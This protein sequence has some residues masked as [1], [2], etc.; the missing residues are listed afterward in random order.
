MLMRL[1]R[2]DG[3]RALAILLVI[4]THHRIITQVGWAGVDLFFVL[5]GF[6]ITRILRSS[7][8]QT[9]Y[10]SRFYLKRAVRILPP[11]VILVGFCA[12]V[13]HHHPFFSFLGYVLFLGNV[14]TLTRYDIPLLGVLWSLAVEEHF[15]L[16]WPLAIKFIGRRQLLLIL[17]GVLLFE[18]LVRA[19]AT[20]HLRDW[21]P[22]YF[23]TPFRLDSLAA[24]ALIAILVEDASAE[25]W[26]RRWSGVGTV[27]SVAAFAVLSL[28]VP[29]FSR[30]SNSVS[31]NAIGYSL[32]AGIAFFFVARV[33]LVPTDW[34]G[35]LLSTKPIV[36]LGRVSY[37][38]YLYHQVVFTILRKALHIPFDNPDV[39]ALRRLFP[40]EFAIT[41]VV[42]AISFR[43]YETPILRWGNRL[44]IRREIAVGDST[45]SE[46][47]A[48][49]A[50]P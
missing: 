43:F 21:S 44:A 27:V 39:G 2:L 40:M 5:S 19:L 46:Q 1:A 13:S 36:Y 47:D 38:I 16:A 41:L 7:F 45:A 12:I 26:L 28:F 20:P 35:T 17:G 8:T 18:P 30:E 22:I 4:L 42:A 32:I 48:V 24:G 34:L 33:L 31:F 37:G 23:L 10:W 9:T 25:T 14:V 11:F 29:T 50:T 15:Y 49:A 6:L 3:I